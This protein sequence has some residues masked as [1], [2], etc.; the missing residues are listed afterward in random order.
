MP[1]QL[2]EP[3]DVPAET[4][5]VARAAFPVGTL[6]GSSTERGLSNTYGVDGRGPLTAL[7][8]SDG[9]LGLNR[10]TKS[11]KSSHR[12]CG[13]EGFSRICW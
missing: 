3:E 9:Q 12:Y 8:M 13:S 1:M 11:A 7:P 2:A 10:A 6:C 5:R 4:L